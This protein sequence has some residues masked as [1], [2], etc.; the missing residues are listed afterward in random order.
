MYKSSMD[1][2]IENKTNR[3]TSCSSELQQF[4]QI[5]EHLSQLGLPHGGRGHHYRVREKHCAW[6]RCTLN[7]QDVLSWWSN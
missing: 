3:S 7:L 4:V 2:E 1:Y 5:I 6:I